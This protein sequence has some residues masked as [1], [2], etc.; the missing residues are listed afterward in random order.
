MK[1]KEIFRKYRVWFLLAGFVL[2]VSVAYPRFLES[3][4]LFNVLRQT[5]INAIIAAGMTF[6]IL[7][8][9]I[10]ISVGSALAFAGAVGAQLVLSG[11][12]IWII[13]PAVLL[14]GI[15]AGLINGILIAR[16]NLQPFIATL[17]T[18]TILRGATLVF[19]SGK[20]ISFSTSSPAGASFKWIGAGSIGPV[21]VPVILMILVFVILWFVLNH[22]AFG[23]YI[24]AV[25]GN[26]EAAKL[27][28][29]N[30]MWVKVSA[31]VICG[32]TTAI[33]ALIVTARLTSAQ[34]SAGEGYELDAIAAVVLGGTS[35]L[36]GQGDILGTIVGALIIGILN[37][38]LNLMNVSSYYQTI[39]KGLVILFAVLLD[40]RKK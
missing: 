34:P 9:G 24:Y 1:E 35:M 12:P 14:I 29:V 26:E 13:L 5:S 36:G 11:L 10:D 21:P 40:R 18:Q 8:G 20:P 22:T 2:I 23:R 28:G 16:A 15:A 38:S 31:Y 32:V 27:S 7:T 33:A 19:T 3:S 4:N 6:A 37:N 25:G 39:I 30:T 17:V